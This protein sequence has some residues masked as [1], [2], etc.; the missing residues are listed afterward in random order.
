MVWRCWEAT[1]SSGFGVGAT[2]FSST[3][4]VVVV[5]RALSVRV[6]SEGTYSGSVRNIFTGGEK[7]GGGVLSSTRGSSPMVTREWELESRRV[8]FLP[9]F[10]S[11]CLE[12]D[13]RTGE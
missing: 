8:R 11:L 12:V 10:S 3:V 5:S 4:A 2:L 13:S 1:A 7:T 9:R 6:S